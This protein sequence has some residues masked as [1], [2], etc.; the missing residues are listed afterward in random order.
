M[1]H[2]QPRENNRELVAVG[3]DG[4]GVMFVV[5]EFLAAGIDERLLPRNQVS[6]LSSNFSRG[7]FSSRQDS[8]VK[9]ILYG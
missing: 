5:H 3:S 7:N 4:F 9:W 6:Y 2:V 8:V 1:L